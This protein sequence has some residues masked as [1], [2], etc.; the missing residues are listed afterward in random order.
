MLFLACWVFVAAQVPLFAA[1]VAV[2]RLL[3]EA[4]P[5]AAEHGLQGSQLQSLRHSGLVAL[6][7]RNLPA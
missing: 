6:N 2:L 1:L 5:L 7:M 4:A 3:T